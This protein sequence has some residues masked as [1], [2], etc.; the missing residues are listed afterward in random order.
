MIARCSLVLMG[1]GGC[2]ERRARVL[3]CLALLYIDKETYKS[4]MEFPYHRDALMQ[5]LIINETAFEGSRYAYV[6]LVAEPD[7]VYP[8]AMA[9]Y[10]QFYRNAATDAEDTSDGAD[11]RWLFTVRQLRTYALEA[12][13]DAHGF[14][15][16]WPYR[17]MD[18]FVFPGW[19]GASHDAVAV[20]T[21]A[22]DC[23]DVFAWETDQGIA[24]SYPGS[25]FEP[26]TRPEDW[27]RHHALKRLP[28]LLD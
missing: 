24:V 8:N 4:I 3:I 6:T 21:H 25:Q 2:W 15:A 14:I 27:G 22:H 13:R 1:G 26:G 23:G 16:Q 17:P 12:F 19:A 28:E 20:F 7:E 11:T 5:K 10:R 18:L 9:L